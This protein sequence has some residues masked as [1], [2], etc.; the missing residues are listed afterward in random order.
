MRSKRFLLS[1]ALVGVAA[2]A[3]VESAAPPVD[4]TVSLNRA[5]TH[6]QFASTPRFN[7]TV[8]ARSG[9]QTGRPLDA[10]PSLSST[11]LDTYQASFWAVVG[12]DR[13]ILINYE[14]ADGRWQPYLDFEVDA[15]GL[16]KWPDGS[17]FASGDS[18]LITVTVEDPD[19]M[20]VRFAPAGLQFT[21]ADPAELEMWYT[22][23]Q[24]DLNSD[25]A[26][27][28]TDNYIESNQ[29]GMWHQ[30]SPGAAWIL[31]P[32]T[33]NAS[34]DWFEADIDHFSGYAISW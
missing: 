7:A 30:A 29:L 5:P 24:G 3:C 28:G 34:L 9:A 11:T 25:A 31:V 13:S 10:G 26:V 6:V 8:S 27:N 32:T 14:D 1:V 21:D 16:W 20:V 15:G 22:G 2:L 4:E 17:L 12:Q 18:V 23:A 19:A 33:H